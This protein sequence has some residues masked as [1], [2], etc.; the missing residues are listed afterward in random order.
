MASCSTKGWRGV[1]SSD[2]R[3]FQVTYRVESSTLSKLYSLTLQ[4]TFFSSILV[5]SIDLI[6]SYILVDSIDSLCESIFHAEHSWTHVCSNTWDELSA[7]FEHLTL[8]GSLWSNNNSKL[9]P[10]SPMYIQ[11]VPLTSPI[12]IQR[13]S[14]YM[15]YWSI[16][17]G[18]LIRWNPFNLMPPFINH[19][20]YSTVTCAV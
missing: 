11:Q 1:N 8:I 6:F 5:Y 15:I 4:E 19:Q 20:S 12:C 3:L 16:Y 13:T 17:W 7:T 2:G 10:T 18:R 9:P 14:M